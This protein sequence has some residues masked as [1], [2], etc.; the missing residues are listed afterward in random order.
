MIIKVK[1]LLNI[2]DSKIYDVD[3][4]NIHF[5]N[6]LF[7]K[8]INNISGLFEFYYDSTDSLIMYYS[9]DCSLVC[10]GSITPDDVLYDDHFEDEEVITFDESKEGFFIKDGSSDIDIVKSIILPL[11]PIKAENG[12]DSLHKE[13]DGWT[14]TSEKEYAKISE[15]KEDPR[16]VSA[17]E[18]LTIKLQLQ[19]LQ[20]AH[21]VELK[22]ELTELAHL[23]VINSR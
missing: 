10:P 14:I 5:D 12:S 4:S 23:V 17:K 9:L 11:I 3:I 20:S 13:G 18:E 8:D 7:V 19:H 21:L 1:D 6:N 2:K 15:E 16:L 22:R